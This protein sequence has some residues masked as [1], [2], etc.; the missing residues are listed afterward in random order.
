MFTSSRFAPP[1]TCSSATST[2]PWK[3]FAS[4]RRSEPR[5]ACHVRALADDDEARVSPDDERLETG[6]ARQRRAL[7]NRAGRQALD[8]AD[9]RLRVLGRRPAAAADEVHEAVLGER[10]QVAAR[11]GG[12]LVVEPERSAVPAFGWHETYVD[13]TF[14]SPRGTAAS[15]SRR[16]SS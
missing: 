11:V 12:L 6:E 9:D 14:A 7:G 13:A 5:R 2:A 8:G 10:A 4:I 3:S 15:R 16:A 1:R